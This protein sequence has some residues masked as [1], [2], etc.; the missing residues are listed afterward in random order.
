MDGDPKDVA[1]DSEE[2]KVFRIAQIDMPGGS[3]M[4]RRKFV[5]ATVA[6]VGAVAALSIVGGCKD[7]EPVEPAEEEPIEPAEPV[8]PVEEEGPTAEEPDE[9]EEPDE[10][11]PEEPD[12]D[13]DT[14]G[15]ICTCDTEGCACV[16]N[17]TCNSVS[18]PGGHYWY[19]S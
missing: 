12:E 8:E 5:K 10:D 2:P 4:S 13:D 11:E 9:P 15:I 19:P 18:T 3:K 6:S 1:A 16:G 7:D 14:I 17:C